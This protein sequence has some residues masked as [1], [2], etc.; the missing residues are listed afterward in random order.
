LSGRNC[1]TLLWNGRQQQEGNRNIREREREREC[2]CVL[3][4]YAVNC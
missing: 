3:F 1:H 4:N 2:V